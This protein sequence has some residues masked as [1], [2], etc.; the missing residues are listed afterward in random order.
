MSEIRRV[1]VIGGGL[2]GSGI[3]QM[4]ALGGYPTV[5]R[6]IGNAQCERAHTAVRR[7][8]DKGVEK[9][10]LT[11]EVRDAALGKVSFVTDL[12]APAGADLVIEA[13]VEDL[14]QKKALWSTLNSL[15]PT[16]T[17]FA[18]NTSSLSIAAQAAAT[19][20]G[21]RFIGMHFFSPVP[22]MPLV[23]V[24]R[25]L[26]TSDETHRTAHGFV[27]R[28]GKVAIDT[29]DTPG[30]V[31]NRLLVPYML[32]AI[33]AFEQGIGSV[34]D[35]DVGMTLGAGHPMGPLAL[36]DMVGL[37][38]LQRVAESMY[39][40]YRETRFAPP[41]LLNRMVVS[42]LL[43]RKNGVGFYRYGGEEPE[44]NSFIG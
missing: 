37:D 42:G 28:I 7:S 38:T 35:I 34:R 4:A 18:S 40:E 16:S 43:G 22:A 25:T 29:R 26:T 10:K 11:P 9:G 36:C 14:T 8:L 23:E 1:G 17:I 41:P 12:G 44:P 31:V 32:D 27:R 20:R 15:S 24:V 13:I 21:D 39:G 6:E 19:T 2:M 3:V 30:F 5:C 33:R